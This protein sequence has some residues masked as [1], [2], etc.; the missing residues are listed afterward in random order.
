MNDSLNGP[1]C[2]NDFLYKANY[3]QNGLLHREDGPAAIDHYG[4]QYYYQNGR[5]HREGAPAVISH[6]GDQYYFQNGNLHRLDGPAIIHN[7][8]DQEYYQNDKLHRLD[9][10]AIINTNGTIQYW[11]DGEIPLTVLNLL[12]TD[13]EMTFDAQL[14]KEV[15]YSWDS[16]R[17]YRFDDPDELAFVILYYS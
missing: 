3:Y 4:G 9:G 2:Q 6:N 11:I 5:P 12:I 13:R 17:A 8:G 1:A 7:N 16:H 10:P 15:Q 14:V